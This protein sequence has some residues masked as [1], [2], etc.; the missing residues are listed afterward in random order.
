MEHSSLHSQEA[1]LIWMLK[2][3]WLNR[4]PNSHLNSSSSYNNRYNNFNISSN[5]SSSSLLFRVR[6]LK[7]YKTRKLSQE[8]VQVLHRLHRIIWVMDTHNIIM[9][10][11]CQLP[12]LQPVVTLQTLLWITIH[13]LSQHLSQREPPLGKEQR[14]V[15]RIVMR[16][17]WCTIYK[18]EVWLTDRPQSSLRNRCLQIQTDPNP[19]S[20]NTQAP[21]NIYNSRKW[22]RLP[23]FNTNICHNLTPLLRHNKLANRCITLLW[24]AEVGEEVWMLPN[25]QGCSSLIEEQALTSTLIEKL[26]YPTEARVRETQRFVFS[27]TKNGRFKPVWL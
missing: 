23:P 7:T 19:T 20:L 22:C 6:V 1:V 17:K 12:R 24:L 13:N 21:L 5:S 9:V 10:I 4:H 11:V 27:T 3:F 8:V 2:V 18:E 14:R 15:Q 16:F 26:S 25:R